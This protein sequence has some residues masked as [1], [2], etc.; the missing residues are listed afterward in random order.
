MEFEFRN[1]YI[2]HNADEYRERNE[3]EIDKIKKQRREI[4]K[5]YEEQIKQ[6]FFDI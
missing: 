6:T 2:E 5:Q 3:T 4:K 1:R